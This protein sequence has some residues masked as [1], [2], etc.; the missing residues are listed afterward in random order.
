MKLLFSPL[1]NDETLIS[2]GGIHG[3]R[4]PCE[5]VGGLVFAV[6]EAARERKMEK[7]ERNSG[8]CLDFLAGHLRRRLSQK[9]FVV[10]LGTRISLCGRFS[11]KKKH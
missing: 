11:G 3:F 7:N 5:A 9:H 10:F 2:V 4:T 1:W 8:F 6:M